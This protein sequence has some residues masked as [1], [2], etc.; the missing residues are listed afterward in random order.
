M[1][2]DIKVITT[3]N[4]LNIA[5]GVASRKR[6]SLIGLSGNICLEM[7]LRNLTIILLKPFTF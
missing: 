4:I 2:L 6:I 7:L 1:I 3:K 5:V